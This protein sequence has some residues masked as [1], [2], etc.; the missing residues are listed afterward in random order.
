MRE[1]WDDMRI[2]L[3]VGR[4]DSLSSAGRVL[5]MDPATVGRRVARLEET[6]GQT[7]FAKSPQG[8]ALTEAGTRL[9]RH[10]EEAEQALGLGAQ[11]VRGAGEGM[12][13]QIRIGAPDGCANFLL[14]QVCAEIGAQN[15]DLEIQIVALPRIVNLSRREADL[16]IGVSAPTAGRLVV[17]KLADYK[18]HL[19]A[20][21][22][23]LERHP[24]IRSRADLKGHRIVGYIPDMIFDKE[25]DYLA[26]LGL[27]RV[28]LASNSVSVQFHW[29][30][31]GAGVGIVHDF[32][33]P[34]ASGLT[35]ILPAKVELIRSFYLVRHA[36]DRRVGRL[37]TF[38]EA[39][40]RGIRRELAR[41]EGLT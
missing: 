28:G 25:L 29:L 17:Q 12:S 18:L 38:A 33:L 15:P 37:N 16:A 11:A 32:A 14:P 41:L 20:S 1:N 31:Q 6:L 13:G 19:A 22:D 7:L 21:E 5:R 23:Y 3:A 4:G 2:F 8:Y 30:R 27:D 24:P 9:L 26:D 36:D 34:A 39:L 10:A 35:R 40:A